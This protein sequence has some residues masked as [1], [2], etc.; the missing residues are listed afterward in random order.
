M[1]LS[2][3]RYRRGFGAGRE[4]FINLGNR[5][6]FVMRLEVSPEEKVA[7]SSQKRDKERLDREVVKAGSYVKAVKRIA[8]RT[9]RSPVVAGDDRGV[10]AGDDGMRRGGSV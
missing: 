7:F 1:V 3:N 2:L 10:G 8:G 5:H 6:S 4:V 9:G